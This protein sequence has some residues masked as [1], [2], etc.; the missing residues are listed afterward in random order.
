MFLKHKEE[1]NNWKGSVE[2]KIEDKVLQKI[3]K[4]EVYPVTPFMNGIF[5]VSIGTTLLNVD[6]TKRTCTC[7]GWEMLGIPCEHAV[8]VILSIG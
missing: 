1:S 2:P 5:G 6:I 3:A 4:C 8:T 7:R